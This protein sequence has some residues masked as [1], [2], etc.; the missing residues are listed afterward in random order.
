MIAPK[1]ILVQ[2]MIVDS[3]DAIKSL[4]VFLSHALY[5]AP[6]VYTLLAIFF[7]ALLISIFPSPLLAQLFE[8]LANSLGHLVMELLPFSGHILALTGLL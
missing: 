5:Q 3:A 6:L 4:C 8:N 2:T 1:S 7:C